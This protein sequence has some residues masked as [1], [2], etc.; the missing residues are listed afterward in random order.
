VF[1]TEADA[2][3]GGLERVAYIRDLAGRANRHAAE[4]QGRELGKDGCAPRRWSSPRVT[5]GGME[6]CFKSIGI[7][8]SL[9]L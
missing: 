6:R 8:S 7:R 9:I 4:D 2:L 1:D 5:H 3:V